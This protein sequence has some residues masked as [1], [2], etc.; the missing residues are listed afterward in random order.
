M[1]PLIELRHVSKQFTIP[2]GQLTVLDDISF[3]VEKG[4]VLSLIGPSGSGKSTCLRSINGLETIDSGEITVCGINYGTS[5]M[6]AYKLRQN[7]A[8][9]FQRFELFPHMTAQ[10]NVALGLRMVKSMSK[11]DAAARADELLISVGL[12]DQIHKHPQ[13]L[14]GGQQQRVGIARALATEPQVLLCDEPTSALDPELVDEVTEILQKVAESGMTM[15]V[16]THE[17]SFARQVSH[18]C[19]FLDAGRILE[20]RPSDEFFE[21]PKHPRLQQFIKKVLH[22]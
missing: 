20:H 21:D 11:A 4:E 3:S 15:I 10:E 14:S 7:T 8:M 9:V 18:R 17:M 16:V 6:P 5:K 12:K 1:S 2:S 13:N 22:H 19:M